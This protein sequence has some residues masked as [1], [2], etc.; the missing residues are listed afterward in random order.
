MDFYQTT[1]RNVEY[2]LLAEFDITAGSTVKHQFPYPIGVDQQSAHPPS[3]FFSPAS[4]Q[5]HPAPLHVP[6][7]A[8]RVYAS[9]WDAQPPARLDSVLPEPSRPGGRPRGLDAQAAAA[10]HRPPGRSPVC[11][12][13][14]PLC[15]LPLLLPVFHLFT[16]PPR[17]QGGARTDL[18]HRL[19]VARV[20]A[21]GHHD[22]QRAPHG[23][24]PHPQRHHRDPP[25][26][27]LSRTPPS[28][29]C[30]LTAFTLTSNLVLG[31]TDSGQST[32][33]TR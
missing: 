28:L 30:D 2:I 22:A 8:C 12:P 27:C 31:G 24:H 17:Q 7:N 1:P 9:G 13:H 32:W 21:G 23:P 33:A 18:P 20:A 25:H 6:Q 5:I 19:V 14:T 29:L 16:C 10:K 15:Q 4:F 26:V 11:P 3:L